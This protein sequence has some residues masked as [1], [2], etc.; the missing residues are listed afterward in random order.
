MF[1]ISIAKSG[2]LTFLC[3]HCGQK[4]TRTLH[5]GASVLYTCMFCRCIL[6]NLYD[7]SR[8][9]VEENKR[10]ILGLKRLATIEYHREKFEDFYY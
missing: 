8:E 5:G 7:L 3:P 4:H 9:V 2:E 6:P 10:T 1:N